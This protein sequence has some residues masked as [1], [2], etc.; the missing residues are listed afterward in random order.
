[1][2]FAVINEKYLDEEQVDEDDNYM[3]NLPYIKPSNK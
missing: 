3:V 1:M 2:T